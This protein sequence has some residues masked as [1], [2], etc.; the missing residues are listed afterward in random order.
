MGSDE[1]LHVACRYVHRRPSLGLAAGRTP[2]LTSRCLVPIVPLPSC[3]AEDQARLPLWEGGFGLRSAQRTQPA[4]HWAS[5]ADAIKMVK[6]RHL[7]V[8][9]LIV[10]AL[11]G[12]REVRSIQ[13]VMQCTQVLERTGFDCPPWAHLAEGRRGSVSA[14]HGLATAAPRQ[15]SDT[16]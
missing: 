8:A 4:A 15:L 5:W 12:G 14:T 10:S 3:G 11:E 2:H 9:K 7:S 16:T 6:D 13:V 1:R